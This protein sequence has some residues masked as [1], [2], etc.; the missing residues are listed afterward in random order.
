MEHLYQRH[1]GFTQAP[2]NITPDPS[3]LYLSESHRE[4]LAQLTYGINARRGFIVLTG[5]VGTGKT[6]LIQALLAQ[7]PQGTQTALIF[8]LITNPLDLLRYVCEDF[9]LVEP[10]QPLKEAHD[11]IYLLNEF[12]LQKYRDDENA[13]LIIDEAQNLSAEVLESIRLLSN[14]E[15]TKDK[16]L[17]IL[18]VGQPE[19]SE[20]LNQPQLRQLRQRV[21]LRHHLRP[22][23]L[24]ECQEYIATR[25]SRAGGNPN[26]FTPKAV[27]G[28]HQYSG[29]I[30]R[31]I[32]VLC[33]NAMINAYA[34]DKREIELA[35]VQE[36]ADDLCLSGTPLRPLV[37]RRD[38]S[39]RPEPRVLPR[40]E[41]A[42]PQTIQLVKGNRSSGA[43]D[44]P[45]PPSANGFVPEKFFVFLREA[46]VDSMGP[47]AQFVIA[48]QL[49][50]LG[51]SAERF[52]REQLKV[53][54]DAVSREI[55]DESIRERFR[56]ALFNEIR[57][58]Q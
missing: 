20:R 26:L 49:K 14:F 28:I 17:Q 27:E 36:V 19:L 7:L 22:L 4:G 23:S 39:A 18:L 34:L 12:L 44:P 11:Y 3:F 51:A 42:K 57:A 32:N 40:V 8:S 15:T 16:L 13:V 53:L 56:R 50:R 43:P 37:V 1:F 21:T 47:M 6:T 45:A 41:A 10:L 5:E 46:L 31:L 2:F 24:S 48:E 38:G 33:D 9:S 52:P 54:V 35:F 30:P 29:G 25:L 58:L 55:F